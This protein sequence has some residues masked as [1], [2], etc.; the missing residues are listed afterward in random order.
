MAD[1]VRR[2]SSPAR[3]RRRRRARS[4]VRG[5]RRSAPTTPG[6]RPPPRTRECVAGLDPDGGSGLTGIAQQRSQERGT[7]EVSQP[8]D[9]STRHPPPR[10]RVRQPLER[11]APLS[12]NRP[13]VYAVWLGFEATSEAHAAHLVAT[14]SHRRSLLGLVGDDGLGG[15][16][17]RGD[18]R[19]VLQ[20]GAGDLRR[21][22]DA[23]GDEVDVL[24]GRGV[25]A[26]ACGE[27]A[28][29]LRHDAALEAGVDGDL[30]ERGLR[31]RRARCWRRWPRHPR[32]R[33]SRTRPWSPG[34]GPRHHRRRCP[35]R[36]QPWRCARRPR[37]GACAP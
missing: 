7:P 27:R 9:S 34:A 28:D 32:A 4:G 31:R 37:C 33:A 1:R 19:G 35:P 25:E 11:A 2:C 18:R 10:R 20:R 13:P 16:E 22:D 12:G 21:V 8:R 26:L 15:E 30:L 36:R 24:A 3:A 23:R 5:R 29:L 17:Q 14:G 6:R